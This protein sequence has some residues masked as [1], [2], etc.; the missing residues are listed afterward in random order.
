[1]NDERSAGQSGRALPRTCWRAGPPRLTLAGEYSARFPPARESR[2]QGC[3]TCD[4]VR[5]DCI[6]AALRGARETAGKAGEW[7]AE[8]RTGRRN[9][10]DLGLRAFDSLTEQFLDARA[11]P[12]RP[13]GQGLDRWLARGVERN[14]PARTPLGLSAPPAVRSECEKERWK[15]TQ[16]RSFS[17][18]SFTPPRIKLRS[19]QSQ[20][21]R[22]YDLSQRPPLRKLAGLKA[23]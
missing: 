17:C 6:V 14:D 10:G 9:D 8:H 16:G 1:M 13:D 12:A 15:R 3:A 20:D 22:N 19:A 4:S 23:G 7:V 5:S 21:R 2:Q 11:R 18:R